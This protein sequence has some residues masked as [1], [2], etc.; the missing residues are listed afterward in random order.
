MGLTA[1]VANAAEPAPTG[2]TTKASVEASCAEPG[3]GEV[4]CFALRRTDV[5]SE[6]GVQPNAA[7]PSGWGAT[8]LQDAYD[9]P[10]GGGAG[11]TIA[12]VDAYDDPTAEEDLAVYR[13]QYG[14]P[15]CTTDNGCFKKIDQR[16]GT[17]YPEPDSGW[18]GE[19]SL[20][21]DMVSAAAPNARILLV[22]ADS[23]SFEDMGDSVDQAVAQGAKYVSNSYGSNYSSAPGSGE[24]PSETTDLDAHYNHPGVAVVA[25]SGDS[26]YG[27]AYPRP[28]ST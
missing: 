26:A 20:D 8:A 19:I 2:R 25:S 10:A 5:V 23:A 6:K 17:D 14:L 18:A 24:D 12:I 13:A 22:E 3:A 16:G 15:A 7:T 11:Q 28:P 1:P 4:R 27:V 9:L 21:L